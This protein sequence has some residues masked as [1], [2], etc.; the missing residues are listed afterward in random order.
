M[1]VKKGKKKTQQKRNA[2]VAAKS[3]KAKTPKHRAAARNV[4][5]KGTR[6][7]VDGV[8]SGSEAS[9]LGPRG[10]L[11]VETEEEGTFGAR[12]GLSGDLQGLSNSETI[13]SESVSELS[14]EGQDLE[15]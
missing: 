15:A 10:R 6:S 2:K 5:R 4:P 1:A 3:T 7:A 12:S 8:T 13:D 9:T 14:E 11:I